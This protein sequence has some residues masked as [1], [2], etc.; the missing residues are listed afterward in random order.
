MTCNAQLIMI[1]TD[2]IYSYPLLPSKYVSGMGMMV[3][4][5][6][7]MIPACNTHAHT[8]QW[9]SMKHVPKTRTCLHTELQTAT[10]A[11]LPCLGLFSVGTQSL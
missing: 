1:N 10:E 2:M 8:P 7:E 4:F 11:V 9:Q 3:A 5:N 6:H